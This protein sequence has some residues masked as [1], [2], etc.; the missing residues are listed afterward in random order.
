VTTFKSVLADAYGLSVADRIQLISEIW[1][2][3]PED[4]LPP[5]SDEWLAEIQRRSA[6]YDANSAQVLSWEQVKAEALRRVG[7]VMP[8]ASS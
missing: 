1:D 5:L 6:E 3:L 4:S 8:D 7:M 2:T